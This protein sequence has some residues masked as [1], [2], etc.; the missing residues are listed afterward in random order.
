M[1]DYYYQKLVGISEAIRLILINLWSIK[2]KIKLS[3]KVKSIILFKGS[4]FKRHCPLSNLNV[5]IDTT[6]LDS[7]E[8]RKINLKG[9]PLQITMNK[10]VDPLKTEKTKNFTSDWLV[11][12]YFK[13]VMHVLI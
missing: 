10:V 12:C 6:L 9:Y 5:I 8:N 4:I 13:K 1:K 2:P 7:Y 11:L 3:I